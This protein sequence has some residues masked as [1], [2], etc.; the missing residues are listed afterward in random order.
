MFHPPFRTVPSLFPVL[1]ILLLPAGGCSLSSGSGEI[2]AE[3]TQP[4]P[5][6]DSAMEEEL[7][8]LR[9]RVEFLENRLA[10]GKPVTPAPR[11]VRACQAQKCACLQSGGPR[12]DPLSPCRPGFLTGC[13]AGRNGQTRC[14]AFSLLSRPRG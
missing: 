14:P 4:R 8:D 6:P 13:A 10:P 9:R 12:S 2:P 7:Q 11:E 3:E 5:V 1:F